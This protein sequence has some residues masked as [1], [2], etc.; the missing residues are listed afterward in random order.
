MERT[1][2]IAI[3]TFFYFSV[4]FTSAQP[5]IEWQ[6]CLGGADLEEGLSI[7]QTT[8]SGY[9]IAG[10]TT[11]T[12]VS[13]D[14]S[15][16]HGSVD[17][18]VVKLDAT[19]SIQWQKC[20]GGTADEYAY[21]IQQTT[22]DGFI[23]AGYTASNNGDVSGNHGNY[24]AWVVKMDA[25]G[26]I[27]WQ[28]CMGGS[29]D[30]KAYF[31]QQTIDGGY[32]VAG[33]TWS[34]NGDVSGFHGGVGDAWVVKLNNAGV[35]QWQKCLG[36]S[37][38]DGAYSIQQTIDGGFVVGGYTW[39]NDGDASGN[40]GNT[41]AWIV[42]LDDV[43]VLQWQSC[44]GGVD[45]DQAFSIQQTVDDGYVV[46][47]YTWS[48][49]GDVS[50]NHGNADAWIV[51]LDSVG[52][53]QWQRCVG[54]SGGESVVSIQQAADGG[55]VAAGST[56]STNGDVSGFHGGA[57]DAWVVRLDNTGNLQWQMCMGGSGSDGV[58]SIQQTLDGGYLAVGSTK[59]ND[60]D[61]SGNHIGNFDAWV[62]KLG[63]EG[64]GVAE[65]KA[66]KFIVAP[67]PAHESVTIKLDSH[68]WPLYVELRDVAGRMVLVQT[69]TNVSVPI[70]LDLTRFE[71][72]LYFVQLHFADGTQAIERLVKQ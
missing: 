66:E 56:N 71:H 5:S 15:G 58:N 1:L 3:L 67:N 68:T 62:V 29:N 26:V 25:A 7:Q 12:G 69:I 20:I 2:R 24:D 52:V 42:K 48:N 37:V 36:G 6:K 53:F 35:I 4:L 61:V 8:D 14:V 51:K 33:N 60:G 72:G 32:V 18:W 19:G 41:D 21:S 46:G 17:A 11:S 64:V 54:G 13:G 43:G 16:N 45:Q 65:R 50:G 40:H 57:I 70:T 47:G 30:D 44:L 28:K 23:I 34:N 31:T 10:S 49:D 9:V 27:Q 39:S 38:D 55:Y 22:D 63:V 59:S